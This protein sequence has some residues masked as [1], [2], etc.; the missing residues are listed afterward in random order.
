MD[1]SDCPHESRDEAVHV[2][3]AFKDGRAHG[4]LERNRRV[5]RL[6]VVRE[7]VGHVPLAFWRQKYP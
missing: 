5:S 6:L 4:G 2:L 7:S 3:L 1:E